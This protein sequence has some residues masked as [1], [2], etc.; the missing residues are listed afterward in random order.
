MPCVMEPC[1][2]M[3]VWRPVLLLKKKENGDELKASLDVDLCEAHKDL[4]KLE[5]IL[6]PE[7][8]D[9]IQK[10]LRESGKGEFVKRST[11]LRWARSPGA[12]E[13]IPF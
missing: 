5:D 13:E 8:W 2:G 11:S 4:S 6:S 3:P 10:F 1:P 12:P 7:A 9:K